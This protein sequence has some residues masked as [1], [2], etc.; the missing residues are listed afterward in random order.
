[1][2]PDRRLEGRVCVITGTA[3]GTGYA[4]A[5]LFA[6]HGAVVVGIDIDGDR[7][8]ACAQKIT[9]GGGR[10]TFIEGDVSV[11]M[12]SA[13]VAEHCKGHHG[14]CDVVFNNA[15]VFLP[16]TVTSVDVERFNR[17]FAVNVAGPLLLSEALAPLLA[18]SGRGSIINHGS[19]DG[20]YGNPRLAS[21]S[22][23]KAA[24]DSVTRLMAHTYGAQGIR[25]NAIASG[26]ID[27]TRSGAPRRRANSA[28]E[29]DAELRQRLMRRIADATPGGRV[30]T[31]EDAAAV[32]LFL[33]SD[34]A[35]FVNG[36]SIPVTGGRGVIT[37][38][39]DGS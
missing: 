38:G 22:A 20:A 4:A 18:S 16:D 21:Y 35:R 23:S 24:L 13:A 10:A 1:M 33:A 34:E 5:L 32:A 28:R 2:S 37:P 27:E 12:T 17:I 14:G 29:P 6:E 25:A 19:I 30:G 9:D 15:A 7:G 26:Y 31:A 3:S 8:R 39:T 36:A 11:P